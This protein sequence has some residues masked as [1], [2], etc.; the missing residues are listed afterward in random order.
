MV[1][2]VSVRLCR[3]LRRLRVRFLMIM[4]GQIRTLSN[5]INLESRPILILV[6]TQLVHWLE[7]YV[8]FTCKT[9]LEK[10]ILSMVALIRSG[11]TH[12]QV[13]VMSDGLGSYKLE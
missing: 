12:E 9:W 7:M 6:R 13:Y 10:Y 8:L 1:S 3:C 5:N 2:C 11:W 4:I